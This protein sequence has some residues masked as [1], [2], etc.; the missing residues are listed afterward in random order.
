MD[1]RHF[2][3][4]MLVLFDAHALSSVPMTEYVAA[5]QAWALPHWLSCATNG[6]L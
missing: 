4:R 5:P 1:N 6:Y 2:P 3:V